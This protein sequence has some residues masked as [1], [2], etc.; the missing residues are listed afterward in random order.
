MSVHVHRLTCQPRL[1]SNKNVPLLLIILLL[2]GETRASIDHSTKGQSKLRN[3]L[4]NHA[5]TSII[6]DIWYAPR[7]SR[8]YTMRTGSSPSRFN[9]FVRSIRPSHGVR[10]QRRTIAEFISQRRAVQSQAG[11]DRKYPH[12]GQLLAVRAEGAN[13]GRRSGRRPVA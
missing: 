5:H 12:R 1:A 10:A 4:P 6:V 8:P 2:K 9:S 7:S 13:G 11:R 3:R